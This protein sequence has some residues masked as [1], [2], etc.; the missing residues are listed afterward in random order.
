MLPG[1]TPSG[2]KEQDPKGPVWQGYP[3]ICK[4]TEAAKR[5]QRRSER[6]VRNA[7]MR[8]R[9]GHRFPLPLKLSEAGSCVLRTRRS[10]GL[11]AERSKASTSGGRRTPQRQQTAAP[12]K[13]MSRRS[14]EF[15]SP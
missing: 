5:V 13:I 11:R 14:P 3:R 4:T 8:G 2:V 6:L 15:L 1:S 9:E 7:V 10:R 12:R